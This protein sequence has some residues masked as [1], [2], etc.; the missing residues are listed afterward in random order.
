MTVGLGFLPEAFVRR[1]TLKSAVGTMVVVVVLPLGQLLGEQ[2]RVVDDVAF[3][4]PGE[5]FGVDPD[6]IV[7]PSR[8]TSVC[9]V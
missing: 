9:E 7:P 8:S 4:E 2:V 6:G 3:E 1:S 5:L